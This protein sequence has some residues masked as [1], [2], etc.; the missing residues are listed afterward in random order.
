MG[1]IH[2][3]VPA[4]Q[5]QAEVDALATRIAGLAPLATQDVKASLNEIARGEF[6]RERLLAR[7]LSSLQTEDFAEGRAA[8]AEKRAPVWKGR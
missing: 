2:K 7:E 1:Y 4:A 6:D 3:L 8:F 5:L